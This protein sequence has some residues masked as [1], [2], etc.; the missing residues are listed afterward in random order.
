M[1][2]VGKVWSKNPELT[3]TLARSMPARPMV[4]MNS[5]SD[6]LQLSK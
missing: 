5:S 4:R 1:L 3:L 6:L 2:V